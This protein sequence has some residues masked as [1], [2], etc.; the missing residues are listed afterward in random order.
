MVASLVFAVYCYYDGWINP[1]YKTPAEYGNQLFNRAGTV[2]LGALFIYFLISFFAIL[3]TR[4]VADETGIDVNGKFKIDYSSI[5]RVNDKNYEKGLMDLYY[6]DSGGQEKK[7]TL[8]N[9][10]ITSFEDI[11][12]EISKHRPDLLEVEAPTSKSDTQA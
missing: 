1:A 9:Y 10:K 8:D 2:V 12:E 5:T 7:Y 11:V 4:V 3:K 6:K